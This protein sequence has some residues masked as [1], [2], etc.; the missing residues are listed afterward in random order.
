MIRHTDA[1][2][3]TAYI[4]LGSNLGD[5]AETIMTAIKMISEIA[6]I[7]VRRISQFVETNPAGG[8]PDQPK[9]FNAAAK[10][11]T[12]L[13]PH[14]LLE[15]LQGVERALGR[16]RQE[17]QRWGPRTCDLDILLM[18]QMVVQS[19]ELTIPHPRM[20]ERVFVLRPLSDIA[21]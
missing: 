5:R 2:T 7:K 19:E 3:T 10:I 17:E 18:D 14:Q 13:S 4:A 12:Y 1:A 21:A 8:P 9:Y 20:H 15:E 11:D 16:R 6:G